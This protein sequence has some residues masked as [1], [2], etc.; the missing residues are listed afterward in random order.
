MVSF[1]M[2]LFS[3]IYCSFHVCRSP[4]V[5]YKNVCSVL[6]VCFYP[7]RC[8]MTFKQTPVQPWPHFSVYSHLIVF[9]SVGCAC[10]LGWMIQSESGVDMHGVRPAMSIRV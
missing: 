5:R 6:L 2:E 8:R 9:V 4:P 1:A 10:E 7:S 3:T